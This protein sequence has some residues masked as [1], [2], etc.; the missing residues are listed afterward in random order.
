[1]F[2]VAIISTKTIGV[3]LKNSQ[4]CNSKKTIHHAKNIQQ[5]KANARIANSKVGSLF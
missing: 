3:L 2:R 4:I 5:R 1:M